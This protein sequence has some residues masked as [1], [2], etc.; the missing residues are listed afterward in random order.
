MPT[1]TDEI[2]EAVRA[3]QGATDATDAV[4]TLRPYEPRSSWPEN[5]A[6]IFL[7]PEATAVD[8]G[9]DVAGVLEVLFERME[10]FGIETGAISVVGSAQLRE[11]GVIERHYGVINEIANR[12]RAALTPAAE[13]K[14]TDELPEDAEVLGGFEAL[15]AF[16][17]QTADS[18]EALVDSAGSTRL[19][20]G[21]YASSVEIDGRPLVVLNGFHPAQVEYF[22]APGRA[23]VLI[24]GLTDLAWEKLRTE[25]TGATNPAKAVEGS[26]RAELRARADEL[27]LGTVD[28]SRNS[29]HCS[30]GPIEGLAELNRFLGVAFADA[31]SG[32]ALSD[33][34]FSS[35]E[36]Q[37][38][39]A[40]AVVDPESGLTSFDATEEMDTTPAVAK[41]KELSDR[42]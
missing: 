15:K 2:I 10:H 27:V 40:N 28:Q 11:S 39:A 6:L 29:L 17:D 31:R 25:F 7:K 41:L 4:R 37:G 35:D 26:V 16:A 18:L 12:G 21:T 32:Q 30:A 13:A 19:A 20:G 34:G 8:S 22:T 3:V 1:L 36:V 5:Q 9:V 42:P 23:I 14:L 38:L 33:A 24:E